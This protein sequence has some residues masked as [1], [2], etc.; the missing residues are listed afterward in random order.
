MVVRWVNFVTME[1]MM[2]VVYVVILI[3]VHKLKEF[4]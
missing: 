1:E 4:L 2:V 3:K